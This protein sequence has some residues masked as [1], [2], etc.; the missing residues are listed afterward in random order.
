MMAEFNPRTKGNPGQQRSGNSG[1]PSRDELTGILD[2]NAQRLVQV[3]ESIAKNDLLTGRNSVTTSQIR[4]I[5]GTVKTL[6]TKG[7]ADETI[8][9]QLVLVKPKLAYISGRNREVTGLA[10]LRDVLS[11][12]IDLVYDKHD[13]FEN[14][15]KFFE[16]ILAY[17]KAHGGK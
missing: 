16:A 4:N 9:N 11:E 8:I 6:E 5:F 12:A 15:C 14:F 2:G 1:R 17:H 10:V 7:R 13:R 3:A